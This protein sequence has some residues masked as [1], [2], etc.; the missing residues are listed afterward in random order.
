MRASLRTHT[1]TTGLPGHLSSFSSFLWPLKARKIENGQ[2]G[3]GNEKEKIAWFSKINQMFTLQSIDMCPA[4]SECKS[5]VLNLMSIKSW[6]NLGT[7]AALSHATS[8]IRFIA[9]W[10]HLP[11][12]LKPWYLITVVLIVT[13]S[14]NAAL[15]HNECL[16]L[17]VMKLIYKKLSRK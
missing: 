15:N 4:F 16:D 13:C 17:S 10:L 3:L 9:S 12:Q 5:Y 11:Y 6:Q 7:G 8:W 1:H 14:H 2:A